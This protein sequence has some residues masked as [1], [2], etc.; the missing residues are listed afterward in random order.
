MKTVLSHR[1][2]YLIA[3]LLTLVSFL[4]GCAALGTRPITLTV[5]AA[6][7]LTKAFTEIGQQFEA[8][9]GTKVIFNFGS[10]GQLTQQIEAGAPVDLFAAANISYIETLEKKGLTLPDTKQIYGRGRIVLWVRADSPLTVERMADLLKPEVRRIAIANPDHAPYGVAAREALQS[11]GIWDAVQPKLVLGENISQAYQYAT[12]GNVDVGII[13]LSLVM[14]TGEGE[15]GRYV[16]IPET[17]H[18]PLDQALAIIKS[19]THEREARA[20][21]AFIASPAGRDIMRR[22]GFVLPGEN[23]VQ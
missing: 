23:P 6:S 18:K 14:P 21:A 19:T 13:A 5:S 8:K 22:Y 9:T 7:D 15:A 10:T 17:A 3:I 11:A 4:M 2:L 20:F 1:S 12:T 16:L